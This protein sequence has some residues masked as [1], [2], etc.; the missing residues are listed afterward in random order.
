MRRLVLLLVA[1]VLAPTAVGAG[2]AA[3]HH[4]DTS[5]NASAPAAHDWHAAGAHAR[6]AA[7]HPSPCHD[8]AGYSA[9]AGGAALGSAGSLRMTAAP[10]PVASR[11]GA[12]VLHAGPMPDTIY[13]PPAVLA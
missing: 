7:E 6:D 11:T 4:D 8:P 1:T 2:P 10:R 5:G 3:L 13:R 12:A 9:C